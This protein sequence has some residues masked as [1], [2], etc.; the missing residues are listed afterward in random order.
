MNQSTLPLKE[1]FG[2]ALECTT[3]EEREQFLTEAS[4]G[5]ASVRAE[6]E[7]LLKAHSNAGS[8]LNHPAVDRA[9]VADAKNAASSE[10]STVVPA[11]LEKAVLDLLA[12]SQRPGS[13]GRLD[14]Y[15]ILEVSGHGGMGIVLKAVDVKL[16]RVVAVKAMQPHLATSANA[17]QRF[18]REAR[19]AAAV[20]NEHVIHYAVEESAGCRTWSWST[21]RASRCKNG[22]TADACNSRRSCASACKRA[23]WRRHAQGWCIAT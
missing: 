3:V 2:R 9:A 1:I 15:E 23:V 19:A 12:P 14:N 20:R 11:T 5:D 7:A 8:F 10:A 17:R 13:L 6:I 21:F 4:G 18:L 16:Q 22:S